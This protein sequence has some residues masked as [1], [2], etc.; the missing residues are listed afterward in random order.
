MVVPF[1]HWGYF[2]WCFVCHVDISWTID[3]SG[4]CH[5]KTIQKYPNGTFDAWH[6]WRSVVTLGWASHQ[7]VLEHQFKMIPAGLQR[8]QIMQS[9]HPAQSP[10]RRTTSW[11]LGL[12]TC[13][14][15]LPILYFWNVKNEDPGQYRHAA[16][17]VFGAMA[18]PVEF[19][20]FPVRTQES[21][22]IW[23]LSFAPVC[24]G[25][26]TFSCTEATWS[27]GS[28]RQVYNAWDVEKTRHFTLF[29]LL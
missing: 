19:S 1:N 17:F 3:G 28:W 16:L 29:Q 15:S 20:I 6:S 23:L 21:R 13:W 14:T 8:M 11:W 18:K 22:Y 7:V 12:G 5:R 26:R 9:F 25:G 2:L 4:H 27:W 10:A 24:C